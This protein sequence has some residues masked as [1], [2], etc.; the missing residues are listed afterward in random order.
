M[1]NTYKCPGCG[2]SLEY[3]PGAGELV[4]EYCGTH[5]SVSDLDSQE[6]HYRCEVENEAVQEET[7]QDFQGY[8]CKTCGAHLITDEHTTATVCCY[9]GSSALIPERMEG[10]LQPAG[11]IPFKIGKAEAKERFRK[12]LCTGFFT[13]K[14]FRDQATL[15]NIRGVYVPFWLYDYDASADLKAECTKIHHERKGD[16]EYT[17]TDYYM[18]E[19]DARGSYL[20]VPVDA[21]EQMPDD[22]MD[23]MEPFDYSEIKEF[24]MPYLAGYESEKYSYESG[25]DEVTGRVEQRVR[26]YIARDVRDT[27]QGYSGTR[28]LSNQI[29]MTRKKAMYTLLPVWM[30]TYRYQDEN[31]IFAINGQTGKQV[32]DLPTSK[33]K[34][35]SWFFGITAVITIVLRVLGGLFG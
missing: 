31:R 27:I 1:V 24:Q 7:R 2:A 35:W 6:E 30:I 14:V 3:R 23:S 18:V 8:T 12:W 4:C 32:G 16:M 10:I 13:P 15:E 17:H 21:S 22:I 25:D 11:V 19:R 33:Q 5:V 34:M 26:T 29:R 9:C 28:I 20:K